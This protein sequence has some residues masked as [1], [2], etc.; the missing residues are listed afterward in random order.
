MFKNAKGF[1]V[2][3][4]IWIFVIAA[5]AAGSEGD[6][7][8]DI[9]IVDT[10][11][12]EDF[13]GPIGPIINNP[14]PGWTVS[15]SGVPEWDETSWSLYDPP[16]VY[17]PYWNGN[18]CRTFFAG[19]NAIADWLISPI[20]DCTAE[21]SVFLSFKQSHSNSSG[22]PDTAFV[23][24]SI[25][26]GLNWDYTVFMTDSTM[27]AL[28][29]PDTQSIYLPWADGESNVQIAFVLKGS[30]VLTW[31]LDE[32][33]VFGN[34]SDT[35]V[36]EAFNGAWG[37][38]GD[39]PPNGWKIVNEV[40]PA[41]ADG[42]DWSRWY[43]ST[44]GDTIAR[45]YHIPS[46]YQKEWLITPSL[47]FGSTSLCSLS[48][49]VNYWDDTYSNLTDTAFIYGS[50]DNGLTWPH[51]I[52]VY[53][54]DEGGSNHETAYRSYDITSW[55][56]GESQ[57]KI[58]FKYVGF[59]GW[60]WIIDDVSVS[61]TILLSDNIEA[62]SFDY[63]TDFIVTEQSYNPKATVRN[64][65]SLQQTF[66]VNL[67]V[68][69][70]SDIEIYNQTE[71]GITLD[72]LEA[73]QLTF[74]APFSASVEGDYTFIVL[75]INPGDEAAI[76]DTVYAVIP[77]CEHQG[78]G[79][80]DAYGYSYFD[81]T[82]AGGPEFS[83][84]DISGTGTQLSPTDHY[85]M[86]AALPIGFSF[87]FYGQSYDTMWVN[88]HG[89]VH[90][91]VRDVWLGTND[92]PLPDTSSPHAPMALVF[93]DFLHVQ[94]EIG[95]GVYYQYFDE[96]DIDYTVIQWKT[97]IMNE[98][99]DSLEFEL[100]LFE[101]GK[102]LYQYNYLAESISSGLGQEATI[103]L[104]YEFIPSGLSYLCNDDNPA[105]RLFGG[106][107][108][109]WIADTSSTGTIAGLVADASSGDSLEGVYVVAAGMRDDTY[110][111]ENGEYEL[112]SLAPGMY[113]V[114]FSLAGYADTT[115]TNIEV[116]AG[117][118]T[119]LD[120]QMQASGYA[121]LP[122]DANMSL[123]LWP[124]RTIGGDVTFLVN[125]F[126]G[127]SASVQCLMNN[128]SAGNPYFWA[129]ADANGDCI[130]MGSDVVKLVN[131]FR[132]TTTLS[133]CADYPPCWFTTGEAEADGQPVGWPNCQ[134]PPTPAV[135][136]SVI[137][138]KPITE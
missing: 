80:P 18:L 119:H 30:Y 35:L 75:V 98:L 97:S 79:G 37:P 1:S 99:S 113:E 31:Y 71:T 70:P 7:T 92:C 24:G 133:Y 114:S 91:G 110:T 72:S 66:D 36:Y 78:M 59:D 84:I 19:D 106:L 120:V 116:I 8:T 129:S 45:A 2:W 121:Y 109:E 47:S 9:M 57:V 53:T 5:S 107:A 90:L 13:S 52:V 34:V 86:S 85:F 102:L 48:F 67:T 124:P 131:Y 16:A 14:I 108:V 94:Y 112:A 55:A 103:G 39:N 38:F 82:V 43:Y 100:V 25:D 63:P 42:N 89:S 130:V 23:F 12:S 56:L 4:M 62:V 135:P 132:G 65:G 76:D 58:G 54:A 96:P 117:S 83:W 81:N 68:K 28:N 40:T 15:D 74:T 6:L 27:G 111:D 105:N 95:Q 104:E 44:W 46:E 123:G 33:F 77:A 21:D 3:L 22:N 125:Y 87:E 41:P 122:G 51:E 134:S 118:I 69:D 26:G 137:Q 128:P 136:G 11:L 101:D 88:S 20:F 138:L 29:G 93:W 64:M 49:Y 60:W 50:T 73:T 115:F 32:P 17:E 127:S 10:L 61:Q 126:K